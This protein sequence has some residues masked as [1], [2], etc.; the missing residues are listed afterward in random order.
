MCRHCEDVAPGWYRK[1]FTDFVSDR[2]GCFLRRNKD[3]SWALLVGRWSENYERMEARYCPWCG[4][5]LETP[6]GAGHIS[7]D[8]RVNLLEDEVKRLRAQL[9]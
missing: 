6:I 9:G 4:R 5:D 1:T 8:E 7:L 3:G 2:D